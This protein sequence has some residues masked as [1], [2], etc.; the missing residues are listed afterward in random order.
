MPSTIYVTKAQLR[1]LAD[2][3]ADVIVNEQHLIADALDFWVM[4]DT[5]TATEHRSIVIEQDGTVLGDSVVPNATPG[6]YS[7]AAGGDQGADEDE[8]D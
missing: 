2:L 4:D 5:Q 3:E 1:V 6:G 8:E 7:M